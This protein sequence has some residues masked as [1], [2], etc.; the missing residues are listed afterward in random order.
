MQRSKSNTVFQGVNALAWQE[1]IRSEWDE[2][3]LSH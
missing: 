3:G 1:Q 2:T